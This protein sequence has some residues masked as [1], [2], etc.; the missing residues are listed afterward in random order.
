MIQ[1]TAAIFR[2]GEDCGGPLIEVALCIG[3]EHD[4]WLVALA[5]AICSVGAFAIVQMFER[6]RSTGGIQRLGWT[7]LTSLASGATIWCTHFVA[8]LAFQAGAPVTLDP[9]LTMA[10]LVVAVF[11]TFMGI[12][13]AARGAYRVFG[14]LGG[15][16]FGASISS[17]H[18]MGMAAYRVDGIVTWES[19]YVVA[20]VLC[21]IVFAG[22]ALTVLR[23]DKLGRHRIA[24][25]TALIVTAI[26][27]LHF[28]AMTAMNIEP[29]ALSET[30]LEPEDLRALAV[31]TALVGAMVIA[32]GVFAALIDRQTRSDALRELTYMALNDTLTG[33]PNRVG[34]KDELARRIEEA[35]ARGSQIGLCAIDLNRFKEIN[36]LHGHKAGDEVLVLLA[37]RMRAVL[38]RNEI[39]G[40]PGGDEFVALTEFTD[41]DELTSFTERLHAALKAPLWVGHFEARMGASIGVA[42][43]PSDARDVES[44]FNN[45]DLAMY[46]AKT[47]GAVGPRYYDAQLDQAIRDRRELAAD[48]R[49]AIRKS[50]LDVHYQVQTTTAT[51][52]VTGYEALLRWTHPTRGSIPPAVFIP[53]AEENGLILA[54]G[55]WVLRRACA[56]AACWD[57]QSKVAVNVSPLQLAHADLAK[58][59]HEILLETGLPA[60][61]LEIELTET[62]IM[63]DR[64]RSL[65][66]LRQIKALG[67][68]VALDDFGTGYSSLQTLRAFPF[69]KIKL[70]G[71]FAA[72]LE[73]SPQSTAIIRAVLALGKSLSIPVL[74]EGVETPQQLE[75]LLRE[76]CDEVQ[77]F[78][79][80]YPGPLAADGV[81]V[82][83][84][85]IGNAA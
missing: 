23:P 55:E 4:P 53:I 80:G 26:A 35:G 2:A 8:M 44:L 41:R 63:S 5:V 7:F 72:E 84:A 69:D 17:M 33:L 11:G 6:A 13:L 21:A 68:G 30:P 77:G 25:G 79:L 40:R 57:H 67:V 42:V 73:E 83:K 20:S 31:A 81:P 12:S 64:Q 65:H 76:G 22:A 58:L 10:S 27:T 29:L 61:R 56:D 60:R 37:Q 51:R 1:L 82:A 9:V 49:Q 74:A 59:F 18:Y 15:A 75:I 43:F 24:V 38:G 54:L 28:V 16:I 85:S 14:A 3:V 47:E 36:D 46:R 52:E 66:V 71:F 39:V 32:G 70:D 19:R 48:L 34:F 50:Q 78:L 62:A 45:A